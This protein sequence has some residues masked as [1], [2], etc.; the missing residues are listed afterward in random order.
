MLCY[1]SRQT[2]PLVVL[3]FSTH[4]GPFCTMWF[5]QFTQ[6]VTKTNHK[7][8]R[9]PHSTEHD[10]PPIAYLISKQVI[11]YRTHGITCCPGVSTP[12]TQ[13]LVDSNMTNHKP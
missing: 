2:A 6:N 10:T 11:S 7:D 13:S 4:N 5:R 9:H 8:R 12:M 1:S 3:R